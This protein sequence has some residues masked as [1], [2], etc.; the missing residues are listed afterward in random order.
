M[1]FTKVQISELIREHAEKENCLHMRNNADYKAYMTYLNC[2][3]EIHSMIYTINWIGRLNR[4]LRRVTR[5]RT[6]MPSEE[7][8]L[9]LMDS[10]VME[11]KVFV[12]LLPN[13]TC[14]KI[15]FPDLWNRFFS[16]KACLKTKKESPP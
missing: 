4:D 16:R 10:V 15:L 7:S 2:A 14:D 13:I 5:M 11:H 9:T 12:R 1:H 8:V 3:P 6:A